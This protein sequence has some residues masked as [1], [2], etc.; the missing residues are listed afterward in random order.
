MG[1][2]SARADMNHAV[3]YAQC[4]REIDF[5]IISLNGGLPECIPF[6][7]LKTILGIIETTAPEGAK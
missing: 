3:L 1:S 6:E 7:C 4:F 2:I 5:F